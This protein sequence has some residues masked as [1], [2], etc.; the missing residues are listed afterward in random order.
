MTTGA[1]VSIR[2]GTVPDAEAV[3]RLH[4]ASWQATYQGELPAWYL[5]SLDLAART[6]QWVE[7]IA[8]PAVRILLATEG[9]DPLGFAAFGPSRDADLDPAA[10]YQLYNFHVAPGRRS[11]GVGAQLWQAMMIEATSGRFVGL[12]LWVIATNKGARR[13]YQRMGLE[14]DGTEQYESLAPGAGFQEIRYR[15]LFPEPAG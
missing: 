2:R 1:A 5:D 12:V 3:A 10:W 15:R 8:R 14:P 9:D 11:R 6:A 7:R 13:F 4:I